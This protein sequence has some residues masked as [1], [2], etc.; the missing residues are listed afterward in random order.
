MNK[1]LTLDTKVPKEA[2]GAYVYTLLSGRALDCIE[3]LEPSEYQKEGGETVIFQLLDARFP[4]KES[5][6]E[7]SETLTSVFGL[8][9]LEGETLKVW[10]DFTCR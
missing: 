10:I 6:D 9:A 2:R 1:L 4:Q 3:H 8:R 5:S 7:M